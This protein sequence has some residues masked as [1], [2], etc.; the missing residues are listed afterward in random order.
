MQIGNALPAVRSIVDDQT[1]AGFIQPQLF[2]HR[3]RF[4]KQMTEQFVVFRAGL[5]DSCYPFL[6]DDQDVDGRLGLDVTKSKHQVVLIDNGSRDFTVN[7]SLED[8]FA[9]TTI[10]AQGHRAA[11]V[12]QQERRKSTI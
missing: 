8:R 1:V 3:S 2:G 10:K 12:S 9:H 7:D 5:G 6:G 4:E 11:S